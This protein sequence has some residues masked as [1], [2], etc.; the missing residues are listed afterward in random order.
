MKNHDDLLMDVLD[1]MEADGVLDAW[2]EEQAENAINER[3]YEMGLG[4]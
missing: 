4:A 1:L 2:L 3:M